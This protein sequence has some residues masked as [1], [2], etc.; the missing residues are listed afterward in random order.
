MADTEVDLCD[1]SSQS[2][3]SQ[4]R[5]PFTDG[6]TM[7]V[8]YV[9]QQAASTSDVVVAQNA[10]MDSS[11]KESTFRELARQWKNETRSISSSAMFLHPNYLAIIG[12]GEL[13][14][15]YVLDD[16]EKNGGHWFV[17]LEAIALTTNAKVKNPI[18][19]KDYGVIPKMKLAWIKWGYEEGYL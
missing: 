7:K 16:L 14:L 10:R 11:S 8:V 13:V 6:W 19:Q 15:P 17:A 18:D 5:Q 9:D 1:V 3:R 2:E 4:T 12:M